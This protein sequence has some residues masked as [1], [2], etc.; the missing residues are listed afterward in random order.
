MHAAA[1][2]HHGPPVVRLAF[3]LDGLTVAAL[4]AYLVVTGGA[5]REDDGFFTDPLPDGLAVLALAAAIA[6]GAVAAWALVRDPPRTRAG[7]WALGLAICFVVSF[8]VLGLL[9]EALGLDQ[10][11]APGPVVPLLAATALAAMV[12]GAFAREPERRGLLFIPLMI[13]ASALIFFLGDLLFPY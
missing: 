11:W 10:G 8:P 6:A 7:R 3:G 1:T 5:G 9:T 2:G 12:L 4:V 13:G